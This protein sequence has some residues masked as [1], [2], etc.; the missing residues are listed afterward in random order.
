MKVAGLGEWFLGK[1]QNCGRR[2]TLDWLAWVSRVRKVVQQFYWLI[3]IFGSIWGKAGYAAKLHKNV[4]KS[5]LFFLQFVYFTIRS[6][7]ILFFRAL[8]GQLFKKLRELFWK[9]SS[10]LWKALIHEQGCYFAHIRDGLF[11]FWSGQMRNIEKNCL[12]GLKRPNKLFA[13]VIG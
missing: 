1:I 13:N 2:F 12:Q 6:K 8:F 4:L 10:N 7:I 9:I 5:Y 11:F 3:T